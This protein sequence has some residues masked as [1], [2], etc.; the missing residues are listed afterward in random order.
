MESS[1]LFYYS[2]YKCVVYL[3]TDASLSITLFWIEF[4]WWWYYINQMKF[5]SRQIPAHVSVSGWCATQTSERLAYI[6]F[7]LNVYNI[8][9]NMNQSF[10]LNKTSE[11]RNTY[12]RSRTQYQ[13]WQNVRVC[14]WAR[15]AH[16]FHQYYYFCYFD[17]RL[18]I[19]FPSIKEKRQ[20]ETPSAKP[21]TTTN[22]K[23]KKTTASHEFENGLNF[24]IREFSEF[25]YIY[26]ICRGWRIENCKFSQLIGHQSR[27]H[28]LTKVQTQPQNRYSQFWS[29]NAFRAY[30][31]PNRPQFLQFKINYVIFTPYTLMLNC[32]RAEM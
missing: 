5:N 23:P 24:S 1:L 8:Q 14:Y 9:R 15:L 30:G 18:F 31:T 28:T 22:W 12:L 13:N 7:T 3:S 32:H 21:A 26:M 11:N 16:I 4:S 17:S 10:L 25:W 27:T 19:T 29:R 2:R 20:F 6:S